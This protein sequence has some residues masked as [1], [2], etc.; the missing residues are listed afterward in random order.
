MLREDLDAWLVDIGQA[1]KATTAKFYGSRST[2]IRRALGDRDWSTLTPA[3]VLR[4]LD[5]A[6]R[7]PDQRH[8]AP[9]TQRAN[10]IAWEQ[11]QKWAIATG[12]CERSILSEALKKPSGR[13]RER[14]PTP[15]EVQRILSKASPSFTA[16]YRALLLTGS[17]PGELCAAQIGNYSAADGVILLQDHKTAKKTKRARAIPIGDAVRPLIVAAIGD[18]TEGPIFRTPTGQNWTTDKLSQ[19]FRRIR[20]R[21]QLDRELVL[22]STRH[23]FATELCHAQG[24]EAAAAVLGHSGLQTIRRYVHHD[25]SQLV[26]YAN[27][28]NPEALTGPITTPQ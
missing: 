23:K 16:I 24:I 12:R 2:W 22:Y 11:F 13:Q 25:T 7:W 8:K 21:L 19:N 1:H 6:N 27:A 17:R 14:L 10:A 5:Q 20:D 9:D 28:V 4:A 15:E 3:I 26:K 18:R